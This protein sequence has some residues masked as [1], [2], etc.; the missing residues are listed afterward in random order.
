MNAVNAIIPR[1]RAALFPIGMGEN[2]RTR[3]RSKLGAA[4]RNAG[5]RTTRLGITGVAFVVFAEKY[6][7]SGALPIAVL[8]EAQVAS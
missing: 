5:S 8:A 6:A 3:V 1:P 7:V 2:S 4:V